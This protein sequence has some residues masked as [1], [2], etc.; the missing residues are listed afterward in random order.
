MSDVDINDSFVTLSSD[1]E[2][3]DV[4]EAIYDSLGHDEIIEFIKKLDLKC[5]DWGVTEELYKYFVKQ[6]EIFISEGEEE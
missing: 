4:I 6:H 2:A 5:A 3:T 1:I